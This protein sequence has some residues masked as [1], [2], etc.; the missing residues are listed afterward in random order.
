MAKYSDLASFIIKNVG[1][2]DNIVSINHCMTRLRITL[3]DKSLA[4]TKTLEGNK[5]IISC[6]EAEGKLQV[7]IGTHV[8]DVYQEI[9]E[10]IGKEKKAI[11]EKTKGSVINRFASTITKIV[12]PALGVLGLPAS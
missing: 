7:I 6:Q 5:G 9:I 8:G 11:E 2:K 1:G 10:Q 3:K 12:V 4:D